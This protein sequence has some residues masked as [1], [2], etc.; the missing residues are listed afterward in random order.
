MNNGVIVRRYSW[1]EENAVKGAMVPLA[2]L[3]IHRCNKPE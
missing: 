1:K 2:Q 3:A